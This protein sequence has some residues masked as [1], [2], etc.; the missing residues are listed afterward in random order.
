VN[1]PPSRFSIRRAPEPVDEPAQASV[2]SVFNA[3]VARASS[4]TFGGMTGSKLV[5]G[6][7]ESS[8]RSYFDS[9]MRY[10]PA[11]CVQQNRAA[12]ATDTKSLQISILNGERSKREALRWAGDATFS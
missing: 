8:R 7:F 12:M 2:M 10:A 11:V 5:M 3:R 9:S 6:V 1:T 4:L